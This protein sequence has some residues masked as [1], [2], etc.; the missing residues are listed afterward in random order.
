MALLD[1]YNSYNCYTRLVF[2]FQEKTW[3]RIQ[4]KNLHPYYKQGIRPIKSGDNGKKDGNIVWDRVP[5]SIYFYFCE[6]C[7]G[8]HLRERDKGARGAV[9]AQE[10]SKQYFM[11]PEHNLMQW[12]AIRDKG[13][14]RQLRPSMPVCL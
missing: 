2:P 3:E 11:Y 13:C 6:L 10:F 14:F 8:M 4:I 12:H 9:R 7:P 5:C 1:C